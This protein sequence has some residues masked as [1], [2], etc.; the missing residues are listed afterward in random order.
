M[1]KINP[2]NNE[3]PGDLK[4]LWGWRG[5]RVIAMN[6]DM[7]GRIGCLLGFT[8]RK[9][10]GRLDISFGSHWT[11]RTPDDDRCEYTFTLDSEVFFLCRDDVFGE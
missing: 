11:P 7:R 6:L 8:Y 9:Q 3:N 4:A 5:K 2:R 10:T 1:I